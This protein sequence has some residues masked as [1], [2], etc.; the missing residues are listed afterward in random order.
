MIQ[1]PKCETRILTKEKDVVKCYA[2][3][4]IF[5]PVTGQEEEELETDRKPM[6]TIVSNRRRAERIPT[7]GKVWFASIQGDLIDLSEY[8]CSARFAQGIFIPDDIVDLVI[9]LE[10]DNSTI[11]T[12]ARV[13]RFDAKSRVA[14]FEFERD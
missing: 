1:C 5:N 10:K 8:G 14:A 2:C 12:T 11:K 7:A 4:R 9:E 3:G 6:R 13:V